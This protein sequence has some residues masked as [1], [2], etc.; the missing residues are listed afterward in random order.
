[1]IELTKIAAVSVKRSDGDYTL[2]T[3]EEFLEYTLFDRI[4]MIREKRLQFID[5]E[6]NKIRLSIALRQI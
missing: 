5:F 4:K 1:M 6:G 2:Y 3:L